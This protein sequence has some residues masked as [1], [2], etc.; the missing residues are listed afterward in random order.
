MD[1]FFTISNVT[2]SLSSPYTDAESN[3]GDRGW[4]EVGKNSLLFCLAKGDTPGFCLK[5][6]VS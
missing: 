1:S 5:N 4:G 2:E 3:P 6:S